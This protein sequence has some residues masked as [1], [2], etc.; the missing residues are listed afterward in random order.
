MGRHNRFIVTGY[1]SDDIRISGRA[2]KLSK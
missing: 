1:P 2:I